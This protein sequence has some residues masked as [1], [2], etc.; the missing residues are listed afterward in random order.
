MAQNKI[1]HDFIE[2]CSTLMLVSLCTN[3]CKIINARY[4]FMI[5]KT[6]R[7]VSPEICVWIYKSHAHK[8]PVKVMYD[9]NVYVVYCFSYD[10][11]AKSVL[12]FVYKKNNWLI[13][14]KRLD[15]V[16]RFYFMTGF[17]FILYELVKN[18]H[19]VLIFFSQINIRKMVKVH[20]Y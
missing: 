20:I 17:I 14:I 12:A 3:K 9:V 18:S 7:V 4:T 2:K 6:E 13:C 1:K 16:F 19:G 5:K 8:K 15:T 11:L 10:L